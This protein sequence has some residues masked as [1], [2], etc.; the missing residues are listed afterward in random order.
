MQSA[1]KEVMGFD[2]NDLGGADAGRG[3]IRL[4]PVRRHADMARRGVRHVRFLPRVIQSRAGYRE[5][6]GQPVP[7][8][9]SK[10]KEHQEMQGISERSK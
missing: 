3:S 5:G 8:A 9:L 2:D 6:H 4:V 10:R 7:A 1:R